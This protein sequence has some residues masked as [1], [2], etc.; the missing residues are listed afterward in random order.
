MKKLSVSQKILPACSPSIVKLMKPILVFAVT[1]ALLNSVIVY[2]SAN[3]GPARSIG[4]ISLAGPVTINGQPATSGQTLFSTNRIVTSLHSQSLVDLTNSVRFN[5]DEDT[6]LTIET[7]NAHVSAGLPNGR[8]S[9]ALPRGVSLD[10]RTTDASIVGSGNESV[11][12]NVTTTECAGTTISVEKGQLQVRAAGNE[13]TLSVGET[14]TTA[15]PAHKF[16]PRKRIGIWILI[17]TGVGVLLA[18]VIGKKPEQEAATA[19]GGCIDLLSG[20]SNCR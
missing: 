4:S 16:S 1:M 19:P 12:F 9:C 2:G 13:R 11:I 14:V 17:G 10:L 3:K 18:A 8:M 20:E 7:S 5:L 6:D 15:S